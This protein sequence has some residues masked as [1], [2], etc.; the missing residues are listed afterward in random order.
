VLLLLLHDAA[1]LNVVLQVDL[2]PLPYIA[3]SYFAGYGGQDCT[4]CSPGTFAIGGNRSS[5]R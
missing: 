3:V 5:C 1:V 2:L 4:I